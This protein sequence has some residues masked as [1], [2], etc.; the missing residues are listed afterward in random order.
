MDNKSNH[1]NRWVR[2]LCLIAFLQPWQL[3]AQQQYSLSAQQAAEL[4]LKNA[5]D[6][7]NLQLDRS[8]QIAKNKEYIGQALPQASGNIQMQKVFN[9]PVTLLPDFISPS[10]YRVLV[11]KGVKDGSGNP[12]TEPKSDPKFFPAQ[13]G[14]PWQASAGVQFQQLLFQPDL[15]I[16]LQARK[17]AVDLTEANI[18]V[19]EDSVKSNI[20]R[21]YYSILIAEK[22]KSY[23]DESIKRFEKLKIDQEKLFKNGFIER[24]DLDKTQVGLNNLQTSATQIGNL[25]QIGYASLKFAMGINQ[26]DTIHLTDTLSVELVKKDMMELSNFAYGDRKEIQLLNIVKELQV[27]DLKRNKLGYLTTLSTYVNYSRNALRTDFSFFDFSQQ[28]FKSSLWGINLSIPIFDG[29]QKLNKIR[30]ANYSLQKTENTIKNL[31]RGIDLQLN[32]ANIIFT[33]SLSTLDIQERNALLAEK[34]FVSTKKKY[35]QGLGS[36]FE[37]SQSEQDLETAQSNYF[38]SLFDAINARISYLKALG[39]LQ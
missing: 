33:N 2:I 14:V 13:F 35:E 22:R 20:Y 18:K 23:L 16:A 27:L 32:A 39:K 5:T 19:M 21:S 12:I 34:V 37:L 26:T 17:K 15:F 3:I 30:Q 9:I 25:I 38:Q 10:V 11:D 29:G 28:W 31:E 36:S 6:I 4:A 7:K 8:I 24:L 1:M